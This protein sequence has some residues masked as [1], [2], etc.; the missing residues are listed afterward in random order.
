MIPILSHGH[1]PQPSAA[2]LTVCCH[3]A[4]LVLATS[5]KK[6]CFSKKQNLV[7]CGIPYAEGAMFSFLFFIF[8]QIVF[9]V[10]DDAVNH[11]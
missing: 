4:A 8:S 3:M 1:Q 5:K 6:N 7:L 10:F 9:V 11:D 2:P